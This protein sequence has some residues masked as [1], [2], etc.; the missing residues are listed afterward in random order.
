[1]AFCRSCNRHF[2]MDDFN[3]DIDYSDVCP[4]CYYSG[5]VVEEDDTDDDE[6]RNDGSDYDD[7]DEYDTEDDADEEDSHIIQQFLGDELDEDYEELDLDE[8]FE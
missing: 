3:F 5:A 2:D 4:E 8:D 7:Y 6:Y 1:M